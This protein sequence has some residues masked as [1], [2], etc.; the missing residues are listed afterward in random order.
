MVSKFQL[1]DTVDTRVVMNGDP[2]TGKTTFIKRLCH[3][4]AES[5][6]H[7]EK[8]NTEKKYLHKYTLVIPIILRFVKEQKSFKDILKTQLHCLNICE[9]SALI[10]YQETNPEKVLLLLDGF[11]EYTGRS[12]VDRVM[13]KEENA[14]VV[15]ITTSRPH[16]VEQLRRHTSRA[17]DQHVR[18]C[19]FNEKQVEQYIKQFCEFHKLPTSKGEEL[20]KTLS[21]DRPDILEVA[22]IPIRTEMICIVW[23]V[24]GKLGETLADLYELFIIQLIT[25]LETKDDGMN[26]ETK[27]MSTQQVMKY[28]QPLLLRIGTLS[29][30][31]EK[32]NRLRIV[33]STKELEDI[34][35]EDIDKII[36]IGI[37]TKSHPSNILQESKWSFPHQTIQEYLVAYLLGNDRNGTHISSFV[38]RCKDYRVFRRCQVIFSFICSKYPK[39]ANSILTELLLE[40]RDENKCQELFDSICK[41]YS[42]YRKNTLDIP[43]PYFLRLDNYM[44]V[45]VQILNTLLELDKRRKQP[46]LRYLTINKPVKYENFMNIHY[47]GKL[48]VTIDEQ[49]EMNLVSKVI[50][51]LSQ[52]TSITMNSKINLLSTSNKGLLMDIKSDRLLYLSVTAPGALEAV[53]GSIYMFK[54]LQELHIKDTDE[55]TDTFIGNTC[56]YKMMSV[57]KENSNI[58]LVRLCVPDLNDT[59]LQEKLNAKVELKVRE[60]TLRRS[61]LRNAIEDSKFTGI[62]YELDLSGNNMEQEGNSVGQLLVRM[63]SLRVF[64]MCDCNMEAHSIQAMTQAVTEL[65]LTCSLHTLDMSR[66]NLESGGTCLGELVALIPDMFTLELG[67][68]NLTDTDLVSMASR[69]PAATGIRKLNLRDNNLG[70]SN[71]GLVNLLSHTPHLAALAVG[72]SHPTGP[73][74]ALCAA[75]YSGYLSKLRVL[76]MFNS[77][78]EPWC[79]EKLG[80]CLQHM[81]TLQILNLDMIIGAQ[82]EDYRHIFRNLPPSLPHLIVR[83]G[84]GP[85]DPYLILN[86]QYDLKHILR[87]NVSLNDSDIE[88]LQEVLEQHNPL[89][90]V[91]SDDDEEVWLMH[92]L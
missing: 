21:E 92:D 86:H 58:K 45:D 35:F 46:N 53:A 31:W 6:L 38:S 69:V 68:C 16:A 8:Q 73:I 12:A 19:G 17:V 1:E 63:T 49:E 2:G 78:L 84:S 57:L 29:N 85:L 47:I 30:T 34:F 39:V 15:C 79:L 32:H 67:D 50:D 20:F 80:Q 88:L 43:L 52:L 72:G 26:F 64:L 91:Y 65:H 89:I 61:T 62:L 81:R 48:I 11:D 60:N 59:F 77:T 66:N 37:L 71:E 28:N 82:A 7:Q 3:V 42:Y 83:P 14:K 18:L 13:S 9:L 10:K 90:Q 40:E 41:L 76:D 87:L 5:V 33:F 25:H 74:P 44:T 75:V 54:T 4:W 27:N 23:A 22:K 70:E 36:N 56:G 51:K 24:Y 55:N